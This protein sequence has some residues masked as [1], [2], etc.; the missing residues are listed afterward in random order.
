M[1]GFTT[2]S[3]FSVQAVGLLSENPLNFWLYSG[4]TLL[5]GLLTCWLGSRLGSAAARRRKAASI[6]EKVGEG[7]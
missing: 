6:A 1:G 2:Y 3:A 4:T 7:S 5:L